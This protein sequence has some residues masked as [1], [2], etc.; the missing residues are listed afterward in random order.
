MKGA[1]PFEVESQEWFD[2]IVFAAQT[3]DKPVLIATTS[4]NLTERLTAVLGAQEGII[5]KAG[6][7]AGL[8]LP[9][10]PKTVIVPRVPYPNKKEI[11]KEL[12]TRYFDSK[13]LAMRRLKQVLGRGLRTPDAKM[14]FVVLDNRAA[15]LTGFTPKRFK[16][17]VEEGTRQEVVLSVAERSPMLRQAA[18]K[19]YGAKC[20][21]ADCNV[22]QAHQLDVHHLDP[23]A[24]GIRRTTLADVMV[25]CKNHHA[26][27]HHEM[28]HS[29]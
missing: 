29:K 20:M 27:L 25:V 19:H 16:W 23:V 4:H 12:V 10:P 26:D 17:S 15:T 1:Y 13:V 6:A 11:D 21:H 18:L 9:V 8:D 3:G 14:T 5:I 7:W 22:T 24:E 2:A 28:S